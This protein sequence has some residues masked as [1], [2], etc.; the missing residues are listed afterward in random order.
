MGT[1]PFAPL[2]GKAIH[3]LLDAR[4]DVQSWRIG[5]E[6]DIWY[7]GRPLCQMKAEDFDKKFELGEDLTNDL[8]F[9]KAR[10][11]NR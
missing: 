2:R 10:R 9:S 1:T 7:S 11:P 6:F 3:P 8:N 5:P 4:E